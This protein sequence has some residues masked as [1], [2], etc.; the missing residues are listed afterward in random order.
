MINKSKNIFRTFWF[1]FVL[2]YTR[3]ILI[4]YLAK[5]ISYI[6]GKIIDLEFNSVS[7][8]TSWGVA[9][10]VWI[11]ELIYSNIWL[12]EEIW[13]HIYHNIT[14]NNQTL[15][16]FLEKNEKKVFSEII[17]ISGI[18]WKHAMQILSLWLE[19]LTIAIS[20]QD[21][22]TL[23]WIKWVWKKMAE[24][25]ILELKDKDLGVSIDKETVIKANNI[26]PELQSS[27][28]STLTNMWYNPRDIDNILS[29]L[30]EDLK[31]AWEII[32]YVIKSL[33]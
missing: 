27:I 8:L 15:F 24:K 25:L 13:M 31:D 12:H 1:F 14:E 29:K 6:T 17:K 7:I 23:E 3:Y 22:K 18:W 28:K 19:R 21:N 20:N 4:F 10:E 16:G 30:P 32:P 9:Y 11:N 2:V 5:M 33:S 26:N